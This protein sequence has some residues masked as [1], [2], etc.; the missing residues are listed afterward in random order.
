MFDSK[1]SAAL[2]LKLH[3]VA[4]KDDLQPLSMEIQHLRS[5]NTHLKEELQAMKNRL[6][7][8][9]KSSRRANIVVSGLS[10]TNAQLAVAEF[11][12]L[13]SNVLNT[14]AIVKESRPVHGGKSFVF[15]LDSA[16]QVNNIIA[17]KRH[18]KGTTIFVQKDYTADERNKR[19]Q[20]RQLGKNITKLGDKIKVRFGEFCIYVNDIQ[21]TW[22]KGKVEAA[23]IQDVEF[24][25]G[26]VTKAKFTC[27]IIVRETPKSNAKV[28]VLLASSSDQSKN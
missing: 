8:I 4:R 13:C 7:F 20:L 24:L 1:L 16:L 19:F 25:R 11:N 9:D 28:P 12:D 6:E 14:P 21:F 3:D 27:D 2:D 15:S 22:N 17:A 26:I 5:E 10:N 23:K 18:L